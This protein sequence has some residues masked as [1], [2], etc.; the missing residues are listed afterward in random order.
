MLRTYL[1]QGDAQETPKPEKGGKRRSGEE[2]TVRGGKGGQ[3]RKNTPWEETAPKE[4]P[5]RA[6]HTRPV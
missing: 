4:F 5:T 6:A 2:K 1:P 3:G